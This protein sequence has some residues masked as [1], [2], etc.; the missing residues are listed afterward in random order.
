M[1][2]THLGVSNHPGVASL[3][4]KYDMEALVAALLFTL[5]FNYFVNFFFVNPIIRITDRIE[6]F[7]LKGTP[8]IAEVPTHDEVEKLSESIGHLCN[9]AEKEREK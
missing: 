9:F 6:Q 3:A 8:Y 5:I 2:E 1:D 7:I 4:R